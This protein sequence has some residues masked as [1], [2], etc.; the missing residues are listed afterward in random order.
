MIAKIASKS[1]AALFRIRIFLYDAQRG[2]QARPLAGVG[3]SSGFGIFSM[4]GSPTTDA[5]PSSSRKR[6]FGKLIMLH[7]TFFDQFGIS[8]RKK[9]DAPIVAKARL[10]CVCIAPHRCK[11]EITIGIIGRTCAD[12]AEKAWFVADDL[13]GRRR[14]F[15]RQS[16]FTIWSRTGLE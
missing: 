1:F 2:A 6:L 9:R 16:A 13:N 7:G 4:R 3:C 12:K 14:E 15:F 8:L 5:Q 11:D 10:D